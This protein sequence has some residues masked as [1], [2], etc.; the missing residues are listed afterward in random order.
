VRDTGIGIPADQQSRIFERFHQVSES[1]KEV[2]TGIGLALVKE[3]V[4]LLGGS[5]S[6]KSEVGKGSE[7]EILIPIQIGKGVIL[8]SRPT[9]SS[10][11]TTIE[12]ARSQESEV[13]I[14][15]EEYRIPASAKASAGEAEVIQHPVSSI[16]YPVETDTTKPQILVV[17]DNSDLRA[18]IIDCLGSEFSFLQAENGKLGLD[19]ATSE[20]P[21]LIVSDVMMPEMDGITMAA[22]IKKDIRTS[23]IPLILLT[24]K[25][26][27]ES[28]LSGLQSGADDYLTKPF[29]KS[30]LL[31][32]VRNGVARQKRL[33]EK[34][35]L[36]LMKESPKIEVQS[37]DEQFL[38]KVKGSIQARL[39]DEQL[40]VESLADEIGLSRSQLFRKINALTGISVNELIR[41]FRLQKAAQLLA[42]KWGPVSQVAYE[43]GFQ[44]LS[45][46]SK[47]FKE[48]YGVL[49]SEYGG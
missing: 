1:H 39:S 9:T 49:P 20:V 17:E 43:T 14:Q 12:E 26:T 2:G 11:R 27:E 7:F 3:L 38:Q 18:F 40:S 42:Q 15:N 31:L 6:L 22:K 28:K 46:F 37:A 25:S 30:E 45:Y 23:H 8:E 10:G 34:I 35:R 16:Q 48:E 13:G 33:S 24:A 19:Q 44:N 21:D 36:E 29:N 32:K 4:A 5:I 41:K 47:M